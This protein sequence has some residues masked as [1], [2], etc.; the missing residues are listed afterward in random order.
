MAAE[1]PGQLESLR[2]SMES[3]EAEVIV[4]SYAS[5]LWRMIGPESTVKQI[6]LG[7]E[8]GKRLLGLT[9]R[10]GRN[11][12]DETDG[13]AHGKNGNA[14]VRLWRRA[15]RDLLRAE[16]LHAWLKL[17]GE[18]PPLLAWQIGEG[19][20]NLLLSES[21]MAYH[22][23]GKT[24]SIGTRFVQTALLHARDVTLFCESQLERIKSIDG[25]RF[26]VS[27][28]S[29]VQKKQ[30]KLTF[31]YSDGLFSAVVS[32]ADGQLES[33][34][35]GGTEFLGAPVGIPKGWH[36]SGEVRISESEN[37]TFL[38]M[39]LR[40]ELGDAVLKWTFVHGDF[41]VQGQLSFQLHAKPKS[42]VENSVLLS[43]QI[44]EKV[45]KFLFDSPFKVEQSK[46]S[47]P[48]VCHQ[49]FVAMNWKENCLLYSSDQSSLALK[50]ENG[51]DS[52]LYGH[53]EED[54]EYFNP[55]ATIDFAL[56]PIVHAKP[57]ELVEESLRIIE[58]R[59]EEVPRFSF[60]DLQ[61]FECETTACISSV[62]FIGGELE[63]RLFEVNGKEAD[64]ILKFPWQILRAHRYSLFGEPI[65]DQ[66]FVQNMVAVA[67]E[68]L[69]VVTVRVQFVRKNAE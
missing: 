33:L 10:D 7:A 49:N 6:Q 69:E 56:S 15:E 44:P 17:S 61:L 53:D 57:F 4:E 18:S 34:Q 12:V 26:S 3:G 55:H 37:Q 46:N 1:E 52:V 27:D 30:G 38:V 67:L 23:E 14:L 8:A 45:D 31:D 40:S 54:G 5:P 11:P 58:G 64:T 24:H 9:P 22:F 65:R 43:V 19:W 28:K 13:I 62:R 63:I 68:P 25:I 48:T 60:G 41:S 66:A 36:A 35:V 50:N 29:K 20:K 47:D 51:I 2:S 59:F 39:P 16:F 42:G 21:R 32:L